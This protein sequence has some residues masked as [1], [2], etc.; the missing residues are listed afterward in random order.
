MPDAYS[1]MDFIKK[2]SDG[3]LRNP[4]TCNGFAKPVEDGHEAFLFS[5]GSVCGQKRS[6]TSSNQWEVRAPSR[7]ARGE[8][9]TAAPA[10]SPRWVATAEA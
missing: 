1:A 10:V 8:K 4:L 5:L 6:L 9:S 7:S 3:S 2:L